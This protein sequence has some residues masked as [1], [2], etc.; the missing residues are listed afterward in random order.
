M[1]AIS[2]L[3]TPRSVAVIGAS[4]DAG[5]TAGRPVAYLR[6]HG[7]TGAIYPVNPRVDSIGGLR[8]YPDIA[9]LPEAPDVAMI[10]LGAERANQAVRELAEKGAAAAIVLASGYGE[11]GEAGQRRQ[12]ELQ[13]A[14]GTMRILGP[15]TIG[16]VN[17]TDDIP[18]SASGALEMDRF[19]TGAVGLVSQSG[20]I[21]G[22]LLSRA[23]ARGIGMSKLV[24]TSNEVDL[25]LADFIDH[26]VDDEATR[27]IALYV[28]AV[29]NPGK[30]RAACL[31]AAEAG[32]PV[33]AFKIGRSEAGARAAVSHT[34]A[35]AGADRMYD[36]LFRQVGVIRAQTF[37]DFLDIPAGLATGRRL[38][39]RRVAIL[40]STGG[41]GTLV[42][43][44]LGVSGFETPAPDEVTADRLRALQS[45]DEAALD[46]N[47][48]D[49][50]LAGLKPDLLR[51]A[52]NA[53]LDSPT[54][55]AL[56]VIVG[57]SAL[58]MPELMVGAIK[59]C[60]ANSGKPILAYVSPHAPNLVTLLNESGVP[61]YTAPESCAAVLDALLRASAPATGTTTAMPTSS[62]VSLDDLPSGSL[63]EAQAK[64]LFAR[65][66]VPGVRERVVATPEEAAAAAGELGE[67]VVLKILSGEITHKSDVGGV[68]VGVS[69]GAVAGRLREMA[70]EVTMRAG[71]TPE[72]FLV[73]EM[74]TGGTE[75]ILGLHR[76]PLG[77]AILLGMGGVL[78]ELFKDTTLRL[79]PPG[80][81]DR[82]EAL[83]MIRE[84]KSWPLL[85]GYRGRPKGDVDAL[86]DAV[87][88][89]SQLAAQL[90]DR[91]VEAEINP[92][93][94]L[95]AGQGVKAA[96]G[97]AV[98]GH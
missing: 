62:P 17:L 29:R 94:V 1:N 32:K 76:D 66:G 7:F 25:E 24:S 3:F 41:A 8:C 48:I 97:V 82:A 16:L 54:Y 65:F 21:L 51:G 36:A 45:G 86:A 14:A 20:G 63:D 49:V 79:V 15:N 22:A 5:K 60:M 68:A 50:T 37:A 43:D 11:T 23:A 87:A 84:L 88:A 75:I 85:D 90:G 2:R 95:P 44:A 57:S 71:A 96:D 55:D 6:K 19:P 13:D 42:S 39:G 73:Q 58:A 34:G 9:S 81:L 31:R 18:L 69:A 26:L 12:R 61:A 72:R 92:V 27:V 83:A 10:C 30:F 38:A 56:V 59:D 40:T 64:A 98:I 70:G 35:M 4:A 74:V 93:F 77:T 53:L 91:L 47:P 28:E 52:I 46:R 67:R 80:G 89:F 78:A 33:V